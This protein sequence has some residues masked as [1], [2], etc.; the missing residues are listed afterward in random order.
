MIAFTNGQLLESKSERAKRMHLE[1]LAV[2]NADMNDKCKELTYVSFASSLE[3]IYALGLDTIKGWYRSKTSESDFDLSVL[4]LIPKQVENCYYAGL[5]KDKHGYIT[6][7]SNYADAIDYRGLRDCRWDGDIDE[8]QPLFI[9]MDYNTD[10]TS[11]AVGQMHNGKVRLLKT[12]WVTAPKKR[13]DVIQDFAEYYQYFPSKELVYFYDNTAKETDADKN[14][15]QTYAVRTIDELT[16]LG[17]NVTAINL[18]QT[19]HE[20]RYDTWGDI[21][22][23]G[24]PQNPFGFEYN[25]ENASQFEHCATKTQTRIEYKEFHN[26]TTKDKRP[27]KSRKV[28]PEDASHLTE[29]V[30]TLMDGI[31][32]YYLLS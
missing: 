20:N 7:I 24:T 32:K 19:R 12:M 3:N 15:K 23:G 13:G 4:N 6:P 2:L 25:I 30:D 31:T 11:L 21:L 27:E 8:D 29:A 10:I 14:E 9:G 5:D 28:R 18:T 22:S 17:F 26:R 1:N 16:D